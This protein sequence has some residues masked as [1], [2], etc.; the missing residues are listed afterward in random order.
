MDIGAAENDQQREAT[1]RLELGDELSAAAPVIAIGKVTGSKVLIY[2]RNQLRVRIKALLW[3]SSV[4]LLASGVVF[5]V[6]STIKEVI[7]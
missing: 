5:S 7:R 6:W 2:E 4:T 3:V 1:Y